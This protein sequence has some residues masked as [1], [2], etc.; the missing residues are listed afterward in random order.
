MAR[1]PDHPHVVGEV[2]S[3]E[4]RA[5]AQPVRG[6]EQPPL[7]L[8][9][10]EGAAQRIALDR[11]AVQVPRRGQLHR[12]HGRFGRGAAHHHRHVVRR[13]GSRAQVAHLVHQEGLEPLRGEERLGLLPELGLV[14]RPPALGDEQELVGHA[15]GGVDVDLRRQVGPGVHLP[16]HVERGGLRVAQ[17][18][19][20]VGL[21]HALGEVLL[22]L[23]P[24]P[25]LLALLG[26][27]GGGARV[28]AQ[29]QLAPG[30][31]LGVAQEGHG[32]A[33]V[34]G[35]GLRIGEDLRHLLVVRGPQEEGG[36][37]HGLAR[38][39][40]QHRRLDLEHVRALE[41]RH[42]Q[43]FLA[44]EPVAGVVGGEGERILVLESGRGHGFTSPSLIDSAG[45]GLGLGR[46]LG[47]AAIAVPFTLAP[48][49]R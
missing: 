11:Q 46:G 13:A 7:E 12:L 3:A 30:R 39:P 14:G 22:V 24:G 48:G 28:L 4:L 19:L 33:L 10:A 25:D 5:D 34:V 27:D 23:D 21:E 26:H 32:H 20:R 8:G 47:E 45:L 44:E 15:A 16:V 29:R 38:Q 17:V 31:D 36:L 35:R 18:L 37:A 1:E 9:V 43:A 2:L 6:G 42:R 41:A 49:P 40:G